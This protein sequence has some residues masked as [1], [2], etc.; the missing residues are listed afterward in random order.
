MIACV[1]VDLSSVLLNVLVGNDAVILM[2]YQNNLLFLL[3]DFVQDIFGF[4]VTFNF[5]RVFHGK[6]GL[7]VTHRDDEQGTHDREEYGHL[8]V[9]VERGKH[10]KD[11]V[12]N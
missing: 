10:G 5:A 3:D 6:L 7:E 4:C 1:A 11:Y 8:P 12:A 2:L 9:D